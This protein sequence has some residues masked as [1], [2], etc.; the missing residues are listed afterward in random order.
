MTVPK[1]LLSW[2]TTT[3]IMRKMITGV[4]DPRLVNYQTFIGQLPSNLS[5]NFE[6]HTLSYSQ[7]FGDHSPEEYINLRMYGFDRGFKHNDV[8]GMLR[9]VF[10]PF[11]PF[12]A[13]QLT[14]RYLYYVVHVC[15]LD[16]RCGQPFQDS[17]W[18][19]GLVGLHQLWSKRLC[20]EDKVRFS[21]I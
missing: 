21:F 19:L 4:V 13:C 11:Q 3:E 18:R 12:E 14:L 5:N 9:N 7:H 10:R 1:S 6:K 8:K 15:S 16:P 20:Q 17:R 2:K